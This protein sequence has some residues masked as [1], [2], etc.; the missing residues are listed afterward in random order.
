[1]IKNLYKKRRMTIWVAVLLTALSY[2]SYG[3]AEIA[4]PDG[5][6]GYMQTTGGG[7]TTPITVNTAQELLDAVDGNTPAV[8]IIDGIIPMESFEVGSNKTLIGA[9]SLSGISGGVIKVKGTN[10]IFQ[11]LTLGPSDQDVMEIRGATN[12]FV[13]KCDFYD[14]SDE[15]LSIVREADF[16]T[17]SWCRFYFD[18]PDSHSYA[19]LIGNSDNAVEDEGKLHVTLH[20]NWYE[21]GIRG[22]MPRVRFGHVHVYNNYFNSLGN[23]YCIGTGKQC[24]IRVEKCHFDQVDD[25]WKE[26]GAL[27]SGGI[28]GWDDLKVEGGSSIPTYID[29]SYPAFLLPYN[30]S[31]DPVCDI[32]EMLIAGAGNVFPISTSADELIQNNV[33]T[34]YPNPTKDLLF[35]DTKLDQNEIARIYLISP[36]GELL[37]ES[38]LIGREG[39][40]VD[41]YSLNLKNLESGNYYLILEDKEGV[42]YSS[43]VIKYSVY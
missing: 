15:L 31:P 4:T 18:N 7:N 9:D 8:I 24:H 42:K 25:L 39:K 40:Q 36:T 27:D 21:D 41:N 29:N 35:I 3:Q 34:V 33:F 5:Y 19:H 37:I 11:N 13:H 14:S 22:R 23:D 17:V 16:V 30:Y 12:V 38:D 6:A 10:Y 32:K 26:F 2:V 43:K 1:M 20:H 28:I